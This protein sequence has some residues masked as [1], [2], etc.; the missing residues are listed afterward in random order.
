M[1]IT[2]VSNILVIIVVGDSEQYRK[3]SFY[4]DKIDN[5][6]S[7]TTIVSLEM[8]TRGQYR[9][10]LYDSDKAVPRTTSWR[11]KKRRLDKINH[12]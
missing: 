3:I 12:I 7:P 11:N 9:S 1:R 4:I 2:V 5:I 10:Y 8:A 6:I